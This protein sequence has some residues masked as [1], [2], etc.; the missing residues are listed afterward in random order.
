MHIALV[1][2]VYRSH[3]LCLVISQLVPHF[4]WWNQYDI[5]LTAGSLD[6]I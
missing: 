5:M 2:W 1:A 6:Y 3:N 4:Y